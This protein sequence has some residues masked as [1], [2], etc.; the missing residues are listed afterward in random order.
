MREEVLKLLTN[1]HEAKDL[2]E[3][4]DMLGLKT[5]KDLKELQDVINELV[6]EYIV[7]NTK[8]GKYILLA[9]CPGLKIGRLTVNKKGF[10][11]IV[12]E[13]EDDLY[14]DD[15]NLNGAIHDDIVL[16]EVFTKGVR[17]EAKIIKV[18][19]REFKNLVGEV[20]YEDGDAFIKLDDD[21]RDILIHLTTVLLAIK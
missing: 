20:Y 6:E 4:N 13:R 9:N 16:A 14:V 12:L 2:I 18:I 7:F 10:G 1:I 3:I 8:K 11:F 21:K 5:A 15:S 19:K 17:K